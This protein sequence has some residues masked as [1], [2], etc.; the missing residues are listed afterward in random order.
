MVSLLSEKPVWNIGFHNAW[1]EFT[2]CDNRSW[3]NKRNV[4]L[5]NVYVF[6][7]T[8]ALIFWQT[9]EQKSRRMKKEGKTINNSIRNKHEYRQRN[10]CKKN[11]IGLEV[12]NKWD[13]K[14]FIYCVFFFSSLAWL[15][16]EDYGNYWKWQSNFDN[17]ML[18][19]TWN[20]TLKCSF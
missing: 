3:Q 12:E 11:E 17:N 10:G 16:T 8:C 1:L 2:H 7:V 9:K 15:L 5:F 18:H 6:C 20:G 13:N 14:S 4:A 19:L